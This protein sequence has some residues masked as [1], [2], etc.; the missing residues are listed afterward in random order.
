VLH[1]AAVSVA[2]RAVPAYAPEVH[3]RMPSQSQSL[4]HAPFA[5]FASAWW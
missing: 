5:F 1:V 4:A 2:G 3:D